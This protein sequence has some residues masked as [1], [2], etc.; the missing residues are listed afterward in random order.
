MN[1]TPRAAEEKRPANLTVKELIQEQTRLINKMQGR[2]SEVM[3]AGEYQRL[4]TIQ[5]LLSTISELKN[6]YR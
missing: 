5:G 4:R 6:N 2:E 1:L 3:I